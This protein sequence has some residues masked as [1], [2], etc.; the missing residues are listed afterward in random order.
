MNAS[1]VLTNVALLLV[2]VS[3]WD[4]MKRGERLDPKHRTWLLTA[5]IFA[6]SGI[7]TALLR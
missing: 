5:G 4:D 7:L 1:I 3:F 2:V 6:I